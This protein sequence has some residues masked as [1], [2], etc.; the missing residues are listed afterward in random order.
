MYLYKAHLREKPMPFAKSRVLHSAKWKFIFILVCVVFGVSACDNFELVERGQSAD[1]DRGGSNPPTPPDDNVVDTPTFNPAAGNV[2][3]GTTVTISTLTSGATIYYTLDGSQ[4]HIN[5]TE[6]TAPIALGDGNRTIKAL[7]VLEGY[8]NSQVA[9]ADYVVGDI[10]QT[11]FQE[12]NG[13]VTMEAEAAQEIVAGAT[14]TLQWNIV[15][16]DDAFEDALIQAPDTTEKTDTS[17]ENTRADYKIY[18]TN[19]GTYYVFIRGST[20]DGNRSAFYGLNGT[21]NTTPAYFEFSAAA[22][23]D[24]VWEN[25]ADTQG[26]ATI[27]IPAQGEYAFN[28]WM[29]SPNLKIDQII[30]SMDANYIP[31]NDPTDPTDPNTVATPTFNPP[32]GTLASGATVEIASATP[33]A[34]IYYT[35]DGSDPTNASTEYPGTAITLED[36]TVVLKALAVLDGYSD[37][38]IGSASYVVG[39][40]DDGLFQEID[41]RVNIEA[42]N[43]HELTAAPGGAEWSEVTPVGAFDGAAIKAPNVSGGFGDYT[44]STRVDY[45]I[46]FTNPGTYRIWLR[47]PGDA[48]D[49]SAYVGLNGALVSPP[50]FRLNIG[51]GDWQWDEARNGPFTVTIPSAGVY[52]LNLWARNDDLVIDHIY[53]TSIDGDTPPVTDPIDPDPA[54]VATPVINPASGTIASGGTITISTDTTGAAIY[55][56]TDDSAPT[57]SS[58]LYNGPIALA[59]NTYTIRAIGVLA[60]MTDSTEATA[61]I[62]VGGTVNDGLFQEVDGKVNIEAENYHVL[63][64]AT[65]GAEWAEVTP[66]GAFDGA[67]IKAPNVS[68]GFGDYNT[69]TRADYDINFTNPGTYRIWLRWPGDATDLSAYIGLNGALVSNPRF[70]LAPGTGDWQWD[71]SR[72]GPFTVTIPSEGVYTLNLWARNDDLVIDHIY[73]TSVDGDM[74]PVTDPVD[75]DATATEAPTFDPS[76]GTFGPGAEVSLATTTP[77]ASIYYT[78]DGS[79]PD[80]FAT[81]YTGT[82]IALGLGETEIRAIATADDLTDSPIATATYI[83][84]DSD[85]GRVFQE[86]GGLVVMEGE[87][88]SSLTPATN[89]PFD[90][91]SWSRVSTAGATGRA[92]IQ[93]PYIELGVEREDHE[94]G[95]RVDYTI[96]FTT[97]GTYYLWLRGSRSS[98][99]AASLFVGLDGEILATPNT[100]F[101]F[102]RFADWSATWE[103][104]DSSSQTT[105]HEI[106]ID[107]AGTY[108]LNLW[109]RYSDVVVDKI[110]LTNDEGYTP[111]GDGPA[112]S[113]SS[114]GITT[115]APPT[116]SPDGGSFAGTVDVSLSSSTGGSIYY[117][118]DG[119]TPTTSST[120]YSGPFTLSNTTTVQAITVRPGFSNS[121]ANKARFTVNPTADTVFLEEDGTV[122]MEAENYHRTVA[123]TVDGSRSWTIVDGGTGASGTAT[124]NAVQAPVGADINIGTHPY[125]GQLAQLDYN[126]D[127]TSPGIYTLWVRGITTLSPAADYE[128]VRIAIDGAIVEPSATND[129]HLSLKLGEVGRNVW[130]W[131][132]KLYGKPPIT[133]FVVRIESTGVHTLSLVMRDSDLIIDQIMLTQD[134]TIDPNVTPPAAE[135]ASSVG[136]P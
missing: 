84:T 80:T 64:A 65:G 119:S 135:S 3:S 14:D 56:T 102:K 45:D 72:N 30:L 125:I 28:L 68:G 124:A 47:W 46:N 69:S 99:A 136:S 60:G 8:D 97:T 15:D 5:S 89:P 41:G 133:T 76:G 73:L 78:V 116:I 25:N 1:D 115:V 22:E 49:L 92:V 113:T 20:A 81:E 117:T 12:K 106:Q 66:A 108:T 42:E 24:W 131:N 26:V 85:A 38:V 51:T 127:F 87:N 86:S 103:W 33:G 122:V 9:T 114:G 95:P 4:P 94:Q 121:T 19:P 111:T 57:T 105:V 123:S 67:A 18:F 58:T 62:T 55:Y 6:Y 93:S 126:I 59:D 77:G 110:I 52:T 120:L 40:V 63:T 27:Q 104:D 2:A 39:P 11:L 29:K 17:A 129:E 34:T 21:A 130:N 23:T 74:P 48:T 82:P 109:M 100:F 50:R 90:G 96:D 53:L 13:L 79:D 36:G 98:D 128:T 91:E 71:D 43:Y 35:T 83:V 7:A 54:M 75:P 31:G 70:R 37:S 16:Q 118:T 112:E 101:R 32:S 88:Y 132:N 44:T 61:T 134:A 107:T 10:D